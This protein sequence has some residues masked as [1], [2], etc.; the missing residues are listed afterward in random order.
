MRKTSA[1]A[2]LFLPRRRV[3]R[4]MDG[5]NE[6]AGSSRAGCASSKVLIA[7]VAWGVRR[8]VRGAAPSCAA[9]TVKSAR[10]SKNVTSPH[11]RPMTCR[12]ARC[13]SATTAISALSRAPSGVEGSML[14]S[15]RVTSS[16]VTCAV[17]FAGAGALAG[18]NAMVGLFDTPDCT[19]HRNN[20]RKAPRCCLAVEGDSHAECCWRQP[21]APASRCSPRTGRGGLSS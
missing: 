12:T 8:S 20:A 16:A 3:P 11:R 18:R 9:G 15:S 10:S 21:S 13:R 6:L 2:R 19:N 5:N 7:R 4:G 17:G 1:C 14:S